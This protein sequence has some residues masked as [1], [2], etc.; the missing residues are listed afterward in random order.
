M[1]SEQTQREAFKNIFKD[2]LSGWYNRQSS[3]AMKMTEEQINK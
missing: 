3:Y 2:E 1:I